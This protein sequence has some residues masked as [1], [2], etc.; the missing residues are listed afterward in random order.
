MTKRFLLIFGTRPEAVKMAPI[1][2]ELEQRP[3]VRVITCVTGQHRELLRKVLPW[4]QIDI[5]YN[6]DLM[7]TDQTL[8]KLSAG[9]LTHVT[10]I[11][12]TVQPDL[13]LV[14]GDTTSAMIGAMAAYYMCIPVGHVEAGLRTNNLYSPF[15]EEFNRRMISIIA[16]HHF[17]P[18]QTAVD[19]LLSEN[20]NPD[21]IYLTGNTI[22]DAMQATLTRLHDGFNVAELNKLTGP[23]ILVTTHRRENFGSGLESICLA[24][25]QITEE[26]PQVK[27]IYPVHYNPQVRAIVARILAGVE[28]IHMIEPLSYPDFIQ[29]LKKSMLVLTDSGGIQEEAL[30]LGKPTFILRD[31]TERPEIL[32]AGVARLVGTDRERIFSEVSRIMSDPVAYTTMTRASSVFGDGRAAKRIVDILLKTVPD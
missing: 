11:I 4:F 17:A 22:V 25:R 15:P 28:R 13:V 32:T 7:S 30:S 20:V 6:L 19:S 18:T 12:N 27:I 10:R 8:A 24:L 29:L 31:T 1:I 14:Q 5:D 23:I 3:N 26:H 21:S 2:H 16:T 9:I